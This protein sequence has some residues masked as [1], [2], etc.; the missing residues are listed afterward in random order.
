MANK[1]EPKGYYAGKLFHYPAIMT[2][3]TVI[4]PDWTNKSHVVRLPRQK[5]ETDYKISL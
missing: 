5:H 3:F 2:R 4:T 1:A